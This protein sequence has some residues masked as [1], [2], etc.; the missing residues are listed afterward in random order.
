[1]QQ[2]KIRNTTV[3]K[4]IRVFLVIGLVL[5]L[6]IIL[7]Q[8]IQNSDIVNN[9]IR[10]A[11]TFS[12]AIIPATTEIGNPERGPQYYG[13][14]DPPPNFPLVQYSHRWCWA[15]IEPSQGQYNFQLI[16]NLAT[17]AKAHGGSFG[18]RIMPIND[19]SPQ[20]CLPTYLSDVVGGGTNVDFNNP[21][22]LQRVQV[23]LD[24]LAQR[25]SDDP[26]I[27]LLDMSYEGCY[28]EWNTSCGGTAMTAENRQKLI[29]M[30]FAAFPTKR[31]LMLTYYTDSLTYALQAKRTKPT[32]VRIDCLGTQSLGGARD[33]LDNN[34]LEHNRWKVAPL[35]FEYCP[36]P[37]FTMSLADIKRYHASLIGDGDGN[38]KS[39]SSYNATAQDLMLQNYRASGYRF[40]LNSL[41]LPKQLGG[42]QQFQVRSQWTNGNY[43]PAYAQWNVMVQLRNTSDQVVWR[44]KSSVDLR[45]PFSDAS[46]GNDVKTVTDMFTLPA[47][48]ASGQYSVAVQIVHADTY[49]PPLA[50]A[51]QGR[52]I[53][54]SYLLGNITVSTGLAS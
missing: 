25:Y 28:G 34:P 1:M 36:K 13:S 7:R 50:L 37:D 31:F 2:Q 51:I 53:D 18:W 5:L 45:I 23:M 11:V 32:G 39:F 8:Q 12:P 46:Q 9:P 33:K 38:I 19:H 30:Q 52:Q 4:L 6:F 35:Y 44:G 16:D 43:A 27:D 47:T 42:G 3:I 49:Y 24:A 20:P 54:G 29:D 40:E 26:R 21:Y 14:G 17:I 22:Y 48:I 41:T 10:D 15:A